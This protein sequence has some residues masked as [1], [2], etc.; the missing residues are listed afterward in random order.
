MEAWYILTESVV[1]NALGSTILDSIDLVSRYMH[2][3]NH[4]CT[5]IK[6][7]IKQRANFSLERFFRL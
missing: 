3:C 4:A 6:A 1:Q 7:A 2:A 5:V